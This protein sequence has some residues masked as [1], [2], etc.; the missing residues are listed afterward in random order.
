MRD[1]KQAEG[2]YEFVSLCGPPN[3]TF[4]KVGRNET[5]ARV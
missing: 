1:N 5:R 2:D 4:A 3:L